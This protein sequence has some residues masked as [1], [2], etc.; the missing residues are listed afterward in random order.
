MQ[1]IWRIHCPK[2]SR[3]TWVSTS[4]KFDNQFDAL[5]RY[6]G[7][8]LGLLAMSIWGHYAKEIKLADLTPFGFQPSAVLKCPHAPKPALPKRDKSK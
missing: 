8:D 5:R 2:A 4:E 7:A 1:H 3:P 6:H